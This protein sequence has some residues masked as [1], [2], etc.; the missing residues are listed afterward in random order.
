MPANYLRVLQVL[1]QARYNANRKKLLRR[2]KLMMG[3]SF[4][5]EPYTRKAAA[6]PLGEGE[7]VFRYSQRFLNLLK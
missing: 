1:R 3:L 7:E 4:T 5:L 2:E 6:E